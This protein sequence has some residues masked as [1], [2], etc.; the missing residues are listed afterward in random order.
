F[1]QARQLDPSDVEAKSGL[2]VVRKLRTGAL[3]RE[4]LREQAKPKP[5]EMVVRVS[6]VGDR[7]TRERILAAARDQ[8]VGGG[9]GQ[10]GGGAAHRGGG[11]PPGGGPIAPPGPP[12]DI[13]REARQRQ[14]AE[15]QR[16][17]QIIAETI[18]QAERTLRS[19]PDLAHDQLKRALDGVRNN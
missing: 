12:N 2:E 11:A 7:V 13:L 6:K 4:Q 9:A 3:T 8:D 1:E 15:D 5:D 10:A 19:D 17:T 16:M 18:R 14:A